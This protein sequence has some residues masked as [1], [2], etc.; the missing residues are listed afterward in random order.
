ME[1]LL[2]RGSVEIFVNEGEVP[3]AF[4]HIPAKKDSS[5]SLFTRNSNVTLNKMEVY[6]L[7]PVWKR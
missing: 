4:G 1:I 7:N 6:E 2:D 5:I 3:F